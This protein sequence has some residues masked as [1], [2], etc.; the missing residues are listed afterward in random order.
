MATEDGT[1]SIACAGTGAGAPAGPP[2][3][4]QSGSTAPLSRR[5]VWNAGRSA[6]FHHPAYAVSCQTTSWMHEAPARS[7]AGTAPNSAA[8]AATV[9]PAIH[10]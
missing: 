10:P 5:P 4:A 8:A 1:P 7:G 3:S 2:V 6:G 9:M